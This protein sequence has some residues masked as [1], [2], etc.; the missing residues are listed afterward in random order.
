MTT[1]GE[2][3]GKAPS[4]ILWAP[5]GEHFIRAVKGGAKR[6]VV[7]AACVPLLQRDLEAKLSSGTRPVGYFDH[8]VGAASYIPKSFEWDDDKGVVLNLDRWT[9]R[10]ESDVES[11]NYG[12]HSPYFLHSSATG[13]IV[14]L[15][16]D[17]A[18]VGSLVNEPA[19]ETIERI[20]A[21]S[22]N[23]ARRLDVDDRPN[24]PQNNNNEAGVPASTQNKNMDITKLVA[25]GIL[26]GDEAKAENA[27]VIA[28]SKLETLKKESEDNASDLEE[29]K[30][31][32]KDAEDEAKKAKEECAA[33]KAGLEAAEK[34]LQELEGEVAASKEAS[35]E[36]VKAIV[37]E[38]VAAGKLAPKSEAVA[39][40]EKTYAENPQGLSK[41]LSG[42]PVNPAFAAAIAG[43]KTNE[44]ADEL[45]GL[46]LTISEF[47][48]K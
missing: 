15:V 44:S 6:V 1:V 33:A 42:V 46:D 7:T 14:G 31:K 3:G 43:G 39:E 4:A 9:G 13:E 22:E 24:E 25:L 48:T 8:S 34:R 45:R 40:L 32:K 21:S 36:A 37:A 47:S 16:P 18:E 28:A 12:Y 11:L 35:A 30:K 23:L 27:E 2:N 19:F 38:A 10:G 17:S 29:E 5:K 26:T 41:L 20:A